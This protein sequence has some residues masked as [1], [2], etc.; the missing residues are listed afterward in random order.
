MTSVDMCEHDWP[1]SGCKQCRIE[2][3]ENRVKELELE[4]DKE[5]KLSKIMETSFL[6]MAARAAEAE[7]QLSDR[8]PV[9]P[10]TF[11]TMTGTCAKNI[12]KLE[13]VKL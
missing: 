8:L 9:N 2:R 6:N 3:L 1:G 12:S 10:V 11:K 7:T 13:S 5:Q 4:L